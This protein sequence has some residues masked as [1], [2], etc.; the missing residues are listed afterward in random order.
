MAETA[1]EPGMTGGMSDEQTGK[2]TVCIAG[3]TGWTGPFYTARWSL[4]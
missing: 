1:V 4:V 3:A 2:V